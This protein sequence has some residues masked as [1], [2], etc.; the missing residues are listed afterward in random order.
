M[1]TFLIAILLIGSAA[2]IALATFDDSQ[3]DT[4][5]SEPVVLINP[6]VVPEGRESEAIAFWE[7]ARDFLKEQP[8]YISTNLHRTIQPGATF[9]LINVA[10]WES[11]E[12]FR[13]ATQKMRNELNLPRI[14]GL[15]ADPALYEVIRE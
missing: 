11:P 1:K 13:A 2:M 14:E 4:Q 3:A 12:A 15:A 6:F 5:A 8:G 7:Q 10:V 9:Y